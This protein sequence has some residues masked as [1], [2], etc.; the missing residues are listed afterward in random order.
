LS[1]AVHFPKRIKY[2]I[3]RPLVCRPIT[4]TAVIFPNRKKEIEHIGSMS[5]FRVHKFAPLCFANPIFLAKIASDIPPVLS[6]IVSKNLYFRPQNIPPVLPSIMR[7]P[8]INGK[9]IN[10]PSTT[11]TLR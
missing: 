9:N 10:L 8:D 1:I 7:S 5:A 3:A 11:K 2:P 4:Q 6:A